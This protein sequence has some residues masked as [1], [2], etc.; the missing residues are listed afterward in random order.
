MKLNEIRTFIAVADAQSVQEA[1]NR[2]GLT[3]S[4]VS[5]LIQ[6]LEAELGVMLF[7]RQTKPLALTRDGELALA[8]ARRILA[9]TS[10]FADAFAGSTEP[11]GLL[12]LGTAHVLTALTTGQPL[13]ELRAGFPGLTLRLHA[14]WSNPLIEQVRAGTLDG[15]VILLCE[16][17]APPEDLPARRIG[18]EPVSIIAAPGDDT[19]DLAAMNQRGWVLQPNGCRYREAL[20]QA[21]APFG[22]QPNVTVEAYDQSLLVSLVSRGVGYGLAPMGLIAPIPEAATVRPLDLPNFRM[23]V[24][25]WLIQARTT[26]RIAPVFD[27]LEEALRRDM[28]AGRRTD[29]VTEEHP[30]LHSAAE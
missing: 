23:S 24:T 1:G 4:A 5:R 3:Q 8:H 26:G 17:Q 12:R 7:D 2:L 30:L 22:L 21:L 18:T 6:R 11:R 13:D 27:R 16:E 10:D 29:R 28:A 14:D 9:A 15:A 20:H 25:I 19:T